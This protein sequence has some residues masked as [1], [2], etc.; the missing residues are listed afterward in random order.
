MRKEINP[1]NSGVSVVNVRPK[2]QVEKDYLFSSFNS[3]LYT[4]GPGY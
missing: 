3:S 1:Y 2:L 4:K